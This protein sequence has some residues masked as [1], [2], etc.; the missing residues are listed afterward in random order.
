MEEVNDLS[1]DANKIDRE[2][3]IKKV[4]KNQKDNKT[5]FCFIKKKMKK[6]ENQK[7]FVNIKKD[8]EQYIGVLTDNFKRALFGYSLFN[9]GD[10]YLGEIL[11]EK[12]HGF[13]IYLYRKKENNSQ[14]IYIGNFVNNC[15][16]GKGI[17][18]NT[19]NIEKL[20]EGKFDYKLNEYNCYIGEFEDGILKKGK[21]YS[22][23]KVYQKLTFKNEEEKSNNMFSIEKKDDTILIS[24]GTM[25]NGILCEGFVI[26]IKENGYI[27]NKFSFKV[28]NNS[29]YNFEYLNDEIIEIEMIEKYNKYKL[30]MTKYNEEIQD[31]FKEKAQKIDLFKNNF[32]KASKLD[33]E[34]ELNTFKFYNILFD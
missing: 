9:E 21:I 20:T 13:G 2:I 18:I 19:I 11:D 17:Y 3:K 5:I 4:Y 31:L 7:Y 33:I 12:K 24:K 23:T 34:K 6:D 1:F 26:N 15:I 8:N 25:K 28:E 32:D 29:K 22:F 10:E 27:E 16:N 14:D 30:N